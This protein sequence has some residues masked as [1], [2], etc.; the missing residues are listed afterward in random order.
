MK[1]RQ[2]RSIGIFPESQTAVC[3]SLHLKF[4]SVLE[5]SVYRSATYTRLW[6]F[7]GL[8]SDPLLFKLDINY[9]SG[10]TGVGVQEWPWMS[11]IQCRFLALTWD[12]IIVNVYLFILKPRN[13][14]EKITPLKCTQN[15]ETQSVCL[16]HVVLCKY[17][18][19]EKEVLP[20]L[21]RDLNH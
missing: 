14:K 9:A 11:I 20:P 21:V 8:G 3:T 13:L 4:L 6:E 10:R 19:I 5:P 7:S 12:T 15:L 16:F 18:L 17:G 1:L 2:G